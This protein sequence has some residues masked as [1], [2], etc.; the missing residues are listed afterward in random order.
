[1][2]GFFPLT[3]C[4]ASAL[5]DD[6]SDFWSRARLIRLTIDPWR[7]K[8]CRVG[9]MV[10]THAL[11]S[12]YGYELCNSH[13]AK[14]TIRRLHF[15]MFKFSMGSARCNNSSRG[16]LIDE[17]QSSS[18]IGR[19]WCSRLQCLGGFARKRSRTRSAAD[20]L[21]NSENGRLVSASH[22]DAA[23]APGAS[24]AVE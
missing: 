14:L 18:P 23:P 13:Y 6:G 3:H 24:L 15:V 9:Q 2:C 17:R 7:R 16:V 1:M 4:H 5:C 19:W 11:D 20:T 12:S 8:A 21:T 22:V 10:R